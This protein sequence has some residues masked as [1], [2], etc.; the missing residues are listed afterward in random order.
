LWLIQRKLRKESSTNLGLFSPEYKATLAVN[1][2]DSLVNTL[3]RSGYYEL[4]GAKAEAQ[5]IQ[6]LFD[7]QLFLAEKASK[8]NFVENAADYEI[9]HLAMHAVLDEKQPE[10][11]TLIFN[12]NEKLYLSELYQMN[13]PANLAVLSACNTGTGSIQNGEGVQS[14]SR[15]FTYAGVKSTVRSLWPIPDRETAQIMPLFYQNLKAGQDK[16]G[17]LR[18]AKLTYLHTTTDKA[19]RHPYYWAGLVV[20][21]DT[22]PIS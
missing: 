19:L 7:G 20:S 9:L 2:N 21:G 6:E 12:N 15:A 17:A 5:K 13:I 11:S 4:K 22:S 14:L 16:A 3:V 18:D 10:K 1:F 8:T